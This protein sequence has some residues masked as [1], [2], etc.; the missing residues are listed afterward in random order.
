[1]K[2]KYEGTQFRVEPQINTYYFWMNTTQAPFDDLE[3][4]QAVNY[5]VDP[6]ALERIYAGQL[7]GTQQILPPG[8]PGYEKFEL[9]PHDLA[10]A[11]QTDRRG[12]PLRPPDH[13]LDQQRKPQ[14]RSRRILRGRARGTRLRRQAESRQR[15]QL[16]HDRRQHLD[17]RPRHRLG[18]L[19][20]GL[21][22]PQRL[23]PAPALGRKHPADQQ[24][25]L[26][27]DR[28]PGAERED[29]Q[30]RPRTARARSRKPNTP[31][32]DREF[33]EQAPWAPYGN[34]PSRPSSPARSTSTRSSSTRPSGRT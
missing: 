21:P 34:S 17:A 15:R 30:A 6:A 27:P 1:M 23:L 12:E 32:L 4:R 7:A 29:R 33:M 9:Y 14:R 24:H 13:R 25:Q 18:Q 11:K 19:V 28:R 3:V 5:A 31:Q 20:R 8:M 2:S 16:L 22:A 10:K 26:G